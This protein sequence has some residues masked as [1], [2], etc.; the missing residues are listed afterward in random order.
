M[1]NPTD[2]NQ[3]PQGHPGLLHTATAQQLLASTLPA[4]LAYVTGDGQPRIVPTWFVWDGTDVVMATWV[5][6]PHIRYRAQRIADLVARPDV[7]ISIDTDDNPP[8][9]LQI[10]G[11]AVVEVVDEIVDEYRAAATRYLGADAAQ[12]M[13][14]ALDGAPVTMARISVTPAWVGLLDFRG[15]LPGPLG[16]VVG[17][18]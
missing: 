15:R 12:Q 14:S 17:G 3:L 11:R 5:A 8:V 2:P 13:F 18:A 9:A 16:G 4:R 7:T 1:T 6:G 10:R